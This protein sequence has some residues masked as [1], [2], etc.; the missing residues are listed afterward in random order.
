MSDAEPP[1]R[2]SIR[3]LLA[4]TAS[5]FLVLAAEPL[6]LLV[7]TAVVGHLGARALGALGI[8]TTLMA[9]LAIVGTFVEYGTT[10]RAARWY[11]QGRRDRAVDEGLQA[12][13]LALGIGLVVVAVGQVF[14]GPLARLM[15]GSSSTLSGP[16][17]TWFRVAL[18]GMPMVLLVLA[19]NGWM[20]GVQET[21]APVQ[22]VLAA[23]GLSAAA[24]PVLVYVC[25]LGLVGSAWA[26]LGAQVV[27]ASLFVRAL[28]REVSSP[29]PDRLVM[30]AQLVLGR[31]LIARSAAFQAAFLV[32]ASVAAR[33]GDAQIAAHQIGMQLWEFTA[34]LLDS[35]AIAAQ[36]LVGAALGAGD[37]REA[38]Y[39]AIQVSRW[40]AGAGLGFGAVY[41][42][43][44]LLLPQI[45][46]S[47]PSV[48]HQAHI[49]WPWFVGMLPAAGV[50]FGLD[51]VLIGAGD[52]AF[53]R[54]ITIVAAL[55]GFIPLT[56]AA[57]HF[58]WGIGGVWAGLTAFIVVRLVGMVLR[59]RTDR[60]MVLGSGS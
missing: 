15:T 7:D 4:L 44:W 11:G 6:Y 54:S 26:N 2:L 29:A 24:A 51:G 52:V 49:L 28:Q 31:D 57:A 42:A 25:R 37:P 50:V 16:A 38:R 17:E 43:G 35:F 46:S 21:R 14:A 10:S 40:S 19:G 27:A 22:I 56:L 5:A 8:G 47:S 58:D 32:A 13:Y 18:C 30:R 59:A 36:S 34:L 12:S 39:L 45:F 55:G 41:A 60:W 20:R 1:D 33:M 53:L 48:W 9:L 3:R 23:N